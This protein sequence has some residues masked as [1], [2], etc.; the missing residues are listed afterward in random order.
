MLATLT[1]DRETARDVVQE[2]FAVAL[3]KRRQ[4]RGEGTLEGWVWKIALR[5]AAG[6]RTG[7]TKPL[8]PDL[9]AELPGPALEPAEKCSRA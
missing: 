2:A 5:L 9:D 4:Y 6:L 1:P 7:S 8:P 3:S